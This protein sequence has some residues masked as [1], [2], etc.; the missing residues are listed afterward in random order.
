MKKVLLTSLLLLISNVV[1]SQYM[2]RYDITATDPNDIEYGYTEIEITD[3]L[4][5]LNIYILETGDG[6]PGDQS[7]RERRN[8]KGSPSFEG[9]P[10]SI[11]FNSAYG[12][13]ADATLEECNNGTNI[14]PLDLPKK[15]FFGPYVN[16][17]ETYFNC[18]LALEAGFIQ[19]FK[20][21]DL[22]PPRINPYCVEETIILNPGNF[23]PSIKKVLYQIGK[24]SEISEWK[25]LF[26]FSSEY[27]SS[28]MVELSTLNLENAIN[29]KFQLDYGTVKSKTTTYSLIKCS[30]KLETI[31]PETISTSC[32]G[33]E[34]KDGTFILDFDRPLDTGET[35]SPELWKLEADN[36]WI[37]Q[38]DSLVYFP[39][40]KNQLDSNDKYK[41]PYPL[42]SGTYRVKYQSFFDGQQVGSDSPFYGFEI[43]APNPLTFSTTSSNAPCVNGQGTETKGSI[44]ITVPNQAGTP[45]Y[46]YIIDG[47]N[48]VAFSGNS[49]TIDNVDV[50]SYTIQ[51][52]DAGDCL[53]TSGGNPSTTETISPATPIV[54]N[55]STKDATY[56]G[57]A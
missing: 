56:A 43:T 5:N 10:S 11:R 22:P 15:P 14:I 57:R 33:P 20:L 51:L 6:L 49:V 52:T 16:G 40:T 44:T 39:I 50:G 28:A 19:V 1:F 24:E 53:G 9:L 13:T 12:I 29:I 21:N 31:P 18:D 48:G 26:D 25:V 36:S 41:W 34:S 42:S 4:N 55:G 7:P 27:K 3:N 32:F 35:I 45:P 54:I 47:G 17:S 2:V 23:R 30:P 37:Q 8:R 38:E 46:R